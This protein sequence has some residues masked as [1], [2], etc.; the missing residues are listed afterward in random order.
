MGRRDEN[1]A[2]LPKYIR[3][4]SRRVFLLFPVRRSKRPF[5]IK[6][7]KGDPGKRTAKGGTNRGHKRND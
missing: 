4:D 3:A 1:N 7:R 2:G 5:R 6:I